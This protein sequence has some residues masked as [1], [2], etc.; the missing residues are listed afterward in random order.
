VAVQS[1]DGRVT[2]TAEVLAPAGS[3]EQTLTATVRTLQPGVYAAVSGC[4]LT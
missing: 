1:A 4:R 3:A 2:G